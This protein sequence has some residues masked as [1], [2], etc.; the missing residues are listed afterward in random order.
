MPARGSEKLSPSKSSRSPK[1]LTRSAASSTV[2]PSRG[3]DGMLISSKS[4]LRLRSASAASSSYRV[5]R[6]LFFACR[7]FGIGPGPL[8]LALQDLGPLGVP[9][10]LD[11]QPGLLGIEV[12]GVVALVRVGLAAVDLQD[13]LR[14]VVQEVAVVGDG[15]HGSRI[16]LE[17]AL[18][19]LHRLGVQVV[20]RLVQQQQVGLR[21]AAACRA[22]PGG[23]RRRRA[24]PPSR[25]AAGSAARPSPAR[26]GCRCPRRCGGR[27][28]SAPRPSRP[29]ARRSRHRARPS[30]CRVRPSGPAAP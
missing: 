7:A 3:P 10:A 22:R 9:L 1:P 15:Q 19:P 16:G 17:V 8:E 13:P 2:L 29:S 4:S 25:P 30:P 6:A 11:L 18:Q 14:H 21:R 12:G 23:A 27:A 26:A 5:S 28:R 24:R 20:G